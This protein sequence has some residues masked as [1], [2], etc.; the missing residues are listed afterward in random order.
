MMSGAA[1]TTGSFAYRYALRLL[2]TVIVT[3]LLMPEAYGLLSLAMIFVTGLVLF[4]DIGIAPSVIQSKRGE[5]EEFLKTAWTIKVL[6]GLLV[7]ILGCAVAWPAAIIYDEPQLFALICALSLVPVFDGFM[8]VMQLVCERRLNLK[9]LNII[10]MASATLATI[11]T[12]FFAWQLE[13]VWAL[14]IGT[15]GGA[16]V[17]TILTY[18]F[19]PSFPHRLSWNRRD[20]IEILTFG[21]W[22]LLATAAAF[23][24]TPGLVLIQGALVSVTVLGFITLANT[25]AWAMGEL[26]SLIMAKVLFPAMAEVARER[27]EELR[28]KVYKVLTIV[29]VV[30][31]PPFLILAL[32]AQPIIDLLYDERYAVVGDFLAIMA[33]NSALMIMVA[34]YGSVIL[35]KGDARLHFILVAIAAVLRII[36][37]IAGFYIA[38]AFGMIIGIG[39]GVISY[40]IYIIHVAE[41]QEIG[42]LKRDYLILAIWSAILF[43]ISLSVFNGSGYGALQAL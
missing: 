14:V 20:A 4:S 22:I 25:L 33:I 2:S 34:P 11:L 21:G 31:M 26:V 30:V 28:A 1:W 43:A 6:R 39:V 9:V 40:N 24:S 16:G 35:A 17:R 5:N 12:I 37:L 19:L 18:M 29:Y 7:G 23:V 3:R 8:S 36:P 41:R 42:S 13:S 10:E 15:I 27:P 38:G 32:L